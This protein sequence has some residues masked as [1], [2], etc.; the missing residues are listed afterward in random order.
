MCIRDRSQLAPILHGVIAPSS[1]IAA[2]VYR[3]FN[4][5][6]PN[7]TSLVKPDEYPWASVAFVALEMNDA[8]RASAYR[9]TVDAAFTPQFAYP[10]YCAETGWYLR[11]LDGIVA[12]QT[13]AAD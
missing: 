12:P 8:A 4:A 10:W 7:W 11:V 13:V 1:S 3:N 6:Y 5:A 2:G 9:S